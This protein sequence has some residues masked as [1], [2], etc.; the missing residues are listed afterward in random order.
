[1]NCIAAGCANAANAGSAYC[2]GHQQDDPTR[3]QIRDQIK[4]TGTE[5]S[6]EPGK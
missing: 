5:D 4:K 2:S 3:Q 1:M 6:P